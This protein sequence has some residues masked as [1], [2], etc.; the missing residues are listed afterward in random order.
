M[1]FGNAVKVAIIGVGRMGRPIAERLVAGGYAPAVLARRPET[2]AAAEAVGLVCAGS[3]RETVRDAQVVLTVVFDDDQLRAV[4]LG[5]D[6][7]IAG[8][9][10][11]SVLIQHTTCDP[12]TVTLLAEAGAERGISVLDAAL[13]GNPRDIAAGRLT[14]RSKSRRSSV[15]KCWRGRRRITGSSYSPSKIQPTTKSLMVC[16]VRSSLKKVSRP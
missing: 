10:A 14:P 8:M 7:A 1:T 4:A 3:V 6:G 5:E 16:S 13:S 11:G 12:A 15:K 9:P 2:R